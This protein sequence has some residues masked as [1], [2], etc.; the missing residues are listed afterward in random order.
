[1]KIL[2]L[3]LDFK[4]SA[5]SSEVHISKEFLYDVIH[6]AEKEKEK[7]DLKL[8]QII[9]ENPEDLHDIYDDFATDYGIYDSKYVELANNSM[10]I[11]S[12]SLFENQLKDIRDM[13]EKSLLVKAATYT[14]SSGS[15]AEKLKNEIYTITGLDF[16]SL[17]NIYAKIDEHRLIRNIIVHNGANLLDAPGIPLVSQDN[18]SL[19]N[20]KAEI[21]I[22]AVSGDFYIRD[23]KLVNDFLDLV[24]N[25][26]TGLVGILNLIKDSDL[27]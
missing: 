27:K 10:L 11:T 20:S 3:L 15:Y 18:Y 23:K 9:K 6:L 7:L 16:S 1:M 12:Y 19:I 22:N 8:K 17:D 24:E 14:K 2:P 21:S 5:I 4:R 13:V 25:Y 26:L